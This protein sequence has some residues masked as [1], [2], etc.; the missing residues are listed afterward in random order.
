MSVFLGVPLQD[1]ATNASAVQS[2]SIAVHTNKP[3][4]SVRLTDQ[5]SSSNTSQINNSCDS[6]NTNTGISSC[7]IINPYNNHLQNYLNT[8]VQNRQGLVYISLLLLI[9]SLLYLLH[10]CILF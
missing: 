5:S 8:Y 7:D 3:G 9:D 10:Y 6:I 1:L 4:T 2:E